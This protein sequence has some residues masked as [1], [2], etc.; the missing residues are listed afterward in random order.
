VPLF[1]SILAAAAVSVAP[2]QH[3]RAVSVPRT[4]IVGAPVRIVVAGRRPLRG[5]VTA[6]GPATL[7]ARLVPT[8][9]RGV[10]AATLRFPIAG[11]WTLTAVAAGRATK[12]GSIRVEIARELLLAD[13]FTVAAEP[14]GSLLVGQLNAGGILR[15]A[16]GGRATTLLDRPGGVYHLSR[17]PSGATLV[18]ARDGVFRLGGGGVVRVADASLEAT[19]AAEDAAGNVYVGIYAGWIKRVAPDGS[20]TTVAGNGTEGYSG[21]G[22]PAAAAQIFH[23]HGVA[24]GPDG[25]VYVADTENRRIRRV[26]PA[27]GTISTVGGDV[28]VV[29]ALDV[30]A[31]GSIYTADVVRDGAGG[32]IM[33]TTQA[34]VTARILSSEANG[35]SVGAD[36]SVY[37]NQWQEKRI[38]VRRPGS[39]AWEV[40]ARG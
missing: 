27:R 2:P 28:G 22:G 6:R 4:A 26:D 31:D 10:S 34:G 33:R 36:G 25:A 9:L 3:V 19:C 39:A 17:T 12:L 32:G 8:K 37:A 16:P 14:R 38:L 11:T 21:D 35:V 13:P 23:P 20:V 5:T 1:L 7:T 40:F 29:V 15:V 24:V 18:S 30:A